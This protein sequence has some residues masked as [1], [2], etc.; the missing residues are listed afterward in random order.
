MYTPGQGS[1]SRLLTPH[2]W[3][4][5]G[6]AR[7]C[8]TLGHEPPVGAGGAPRRTPHAWRRLGSRGRA[9]RSAHEPP[10]GAGGAVPGGIEAGW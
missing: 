8:R 4:W 5:S 1:V 7:T 3:R 6:L 9:V 2:A 10:V